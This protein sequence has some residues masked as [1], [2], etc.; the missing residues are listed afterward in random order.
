MLQYYTSF[1]MQNIFSLRKY[2]V[3]TIG[4]NI[5]KIYIIRK[6]EEL[7]FQKIIPIVCRQRHQRPDATSSS[8][9]PHATWPTLANCA[10]LLSCKFLWSIRK[11]FR[12]HRHRAKSNRKCLFVFRQ[13]ET[14][15]LTRNRSVRKSIH[16]NECQIKTGCLIYKGPDDK[17][18]NIQ[19]FEFKLNTIFDRISSFHETK[20]WI[21]RS[22]FPF[23]LPSLNL[24]VSFD[25][26]GWRQYWHC[27][28]LLFL[29]SDI[30]TFAQLTM[31]A[32]RGGGGGSISDSV[33]PS[34]PGTDIYHKAPT[35]IFAWCL[36]PPDIY[37]TSCESVF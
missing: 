35:F 10:R 16:T 2:R 4:Y 28:T 12:S 31:A 29:F 17:T 14:E 21:L 7:L 27:N 33:C 5:F 1:F 15:K 37:N 26:A 18:V 19:R 23:C 3:T 8:P 32:R 30:S 6:K 34:S 13:I 24:P 25:W 22:P 9:P 11:T 36:I 20:E